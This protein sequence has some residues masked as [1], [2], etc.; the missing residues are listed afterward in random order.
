MYSKLQLSI[1]N[2][3]L[4]LKSLVQWIKLIFYKICYYILVPIFFIFFGIGALIL[5]YIITPIWAIFP[6]YKLEK[7]YKAQYL[8][9]MIFRFMLYMMQLLGLIKIKFNNFT[10][11]EQ[12]EGCLILANHPSLLDYVAIISQLPRCENIVK[13]SLWHNFIVKK[14]ITQADYI[15]HLQ[16]TDMWHEIKTRLLAGNNLLMFPEGTRTIPGEKINIKRGAAQI[17]LRANVSIRIIHI[18]CTPPA[19]T[20]QRKWYVPPSFKPELI[21]TVGEK[22]DPQIFLQDNELPSI[23]ARKLTKYIL[24][25]LEG[26][27]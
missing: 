24:C 15:P 7:K 9:H 3:N 23:A 10:Q 25:Q 22:I 4:I 12:D 2:L 6:P 16:T 5:G 13:A 17:A 14:I 27:K 20:K 18:N 19:L 26:K 1:T 8:I 11:L 21:L